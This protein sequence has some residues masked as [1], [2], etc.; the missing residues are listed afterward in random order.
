MNL[1]A[2]QAVFADRLVLDLA[3]GNRVVTLETRRGIRRWSGEYVFAA[4]GFVARFALVL[5]RRT[6]TESVLLQIGMAIR[7]D[8]R[9]PHVEA[10]QLLSGVHLFRNALALNDPAPPQKEQKQS[11]EN[12]KDIIPK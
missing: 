5:S 1:V 11:G 10:F 8:A 2:F 3:A 6:V 7:R 9:R 12:L 4:H